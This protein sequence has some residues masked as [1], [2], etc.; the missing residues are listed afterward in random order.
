MVLGLAVVAVV[1][2]VAHPACRLGAVIGCKPM[3]WI[4]AR[5]YGIY[6]WHFPI[7]V[8]TAPSE[9]GSPTLARATAQLASTLVVAALSWKFFEDPIRHG[10][11]GRL[12]PRWRERWEQRPVNLTPVGVGAIAG[13]M[14]V[15]APAVAGFAGVG[16]DRTESLSEAAGLEVT[17]TVGDATTETTDPATDS[18]PDGASDS[19]P[20]SA[21]DNASDSTIAGGASATSV[22]STDAA[23]A[24]DAKT[25]CT[26]VVHLGDSTSIGLVSKS[27]IHDE[28][29]QIS[30]QY[31]AIGITTQHYDIL[32]G[33][34]IL[35]GYKTNPPAKVSAQK[36]RDQDYHGCWVVGIG[37]ADAAAI[38][39]YDKGGARKRIDTLMA[40]VGNDPVM[41]INVRTIANSGLAQKEVGPP[42]NQALVDACPAYPN[43]RVYDWAAT[44]QDNWFDKDRVHNNSVGYIAKAKSIAAALAKA[45][46]PG[47]AVDRPAGDD[48]CV[49]EIPAG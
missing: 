44:E 46:P 34:S 11:I 47:G 35:E 19:A 3:R 20:D 31:S 13:I 5:S 12:W 18:A 6:L 30:G 39:R 33:R 26:S 7:I 49:I 2:S 16:I 43:M 10:A 48:N 32:G 23:P 21:P 4:G 41:W 42:W 27:F 25:L 14:I 38:Y 36:F 24:A 45:F 40:I 37:L 17:K 28:S 1:A 29:Q 9:G 22:V 8:L 15:L